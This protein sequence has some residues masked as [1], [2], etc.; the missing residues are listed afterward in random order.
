MLRFKIRLL[1]L[2]AATFLFFF[3]FSCLFAQTKENDP[4]LTPSPAL[5]EALLLGLP[6]VEIITI[7]G[8]E[9]TADPI[10][11]PEGSMGAGITNATK[12]PG[13]VTVY[14]PDGSVM[15]ESG[16]YVKKESGMTVKIRGNTS[17][18]TNKKPFKIKLQ[19]KGDLL[20]RGDKKYNDKNWVLIRSYNLMT[21]FGN[22]VGQLMGHTWMP[23]G[24]FVNLVFNGDYR[25][26][27][28][29]QE[30]IERNEKCRIQVE[31][32]GF[33]MEH[34]PYWWN[35]DGAYLE[36]ENNPR[37]NYTFKYPEYEDA[38]QEQIEAIHESLL[39]YEAA[40]NDG[41]YPEVID[42]SSF[43][44]WVL[45]HDV[46]GT[47]DGGGVNWYLTK[48]SLSDDSPIQC[49]P[50][51]DFDSSEKNTD[52]FS[53]V[54][55]GRFKKLFN[56]RNPAFRRSYVER[57]E[58]VRDDLFAALDSIADDLNNDSWAAYNATVKADRKRWKG[59]ESYSHE[60]SKRVKEW[61]GTRLNW[62][63]THIAEL[64]EKILAE[65]A[66]T[67]GLPFIML[68]TC[69]G[70][71]PSIE[72]AETPDG[73]FG[74]RPISAPVNL[75]SV[76]SYSSSGKLLFSTAEGQMTLDVHPDALPSDRFLPL[77]ISFGQKIDTEA[78]NEDEGVESAENDENME[79]DASATERPSSIIEWHLI[80]TRELSA[81]TAAA[82]RQSMYPEET[83]STELVN[84]YIDG[85]HQGVYLHIKVPKF[86]TTDLSDGGFIMKN[87][88]R[89][90]SNGEDFL[91]S[92]T[93]GLHNYSFVIPSA[94]ELTP[95]RI[96][97]IH[98]RISEW[99]NC[100]IADPSSNPEEMKAM[101]KWVL[102]N[103]ILG[104]DACSD[105][106]IHASSAL[107]PL[108]II[109]AQ[110]Y[111]GSEYT[112]DQW[113]WHHTTLWP[114]EG[115]EAF[116]N[117]IETYL[118]AWNTFGS[119]AFRKVRDTLNSFDE[120]LSA[121]FDL[122]HYHAS[123]ME[124]VNTEDST[125]LEPL[126][127]LSKSFCQQTA[128]WYDR[129]EVWIQEQMQIYSD[130]LSGVTPI[131]VITPVSIISNSLRA[132]EDIS[133]LLILYP[134]GR[135]F[136]NS[137]LPIGSSLTLP[138]GCWIINADSHTLKVII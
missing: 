111:T 40:V 72:F 61:Y 51:W 64:K 30:S 35:E 38:T 67:L 84:L 76:K 126:I 71:V 26:L 33:V 130:I 112:D 46:L 82:V 70:S 80:D 92:Y 45:G 103:D 108:Q 57:W 110:G 12:V 16:E 116:K 1:H 131:K 78:T 19:K 90:W 53:T 10:D 128:A 28:F 7:D 47:S 87:D 93:Q 136:H 115:T 96:A 124:N 137:P 20:G 69:D 50:L 104:S 17:T 56:N 97:S 81:L 121:A 2:L 74:H 18:Y 52:D 5:E 98:R 3:P 114:E 14:A 55:N 86:P 25:G 8:E 23:E 15:Y 120:T 41:T 49:G 133:Q 123:T 11:C 107:S 24:M 59:T 39:R 37:Y 43:A 62:L 65:E 118:E 101:V 135:I 66:A 106:I 13:S 9:P 36:S 58:E 125:D 113:S 85:I 63:N 75:R 48:N 89:W 132:T 94:D 83:A 100:W 79:E 127:S 60:A 32:D 4:G 31:E 88:H 138:S 22:K 21:Y 102:L 129:R 27:Y 109:P 42:V 34:D 134:D 117:L 122:S 77:S 6:V 29:L 99:E 68:N 54:H 95:A 73:L 119:A 105:F 91:P 44:N